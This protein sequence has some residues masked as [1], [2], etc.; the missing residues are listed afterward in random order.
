MQISISVT[1][2]AGNAQD[3]RDEAASVA[4]QIYALLD[5][6]WHPLVRAAIRMPVEPPNLTFRAPADVACYCICRAMQ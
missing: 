1:A 2:Q 5:Q 4:S 3:A 6:V